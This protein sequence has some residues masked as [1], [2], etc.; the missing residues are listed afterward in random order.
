MTVQL[1]VAYSDVFTVG[2]GVFAGG[3]Y[4]CARNQ[5]VSNVHNAMAAAD[6][7]FF[8]AFEKCMSNNTPSIDKPLAN[9]ESWSRNEIANV[10]N[11]RHRKV[12]MQTGSADRVIGPN[13]MG[14]LGKQL[15]EFTDT[16]NVIYVT[17][18][19]AAHTF[20]A[21]FDSRGDN[22][23]NMSESPYISDCD[24]DG[25]GA[26]LQ[27]LYGDLNPHNTG[28]LTGELIPFAQTGAY[29]APGMDHVAYL[30][31]PASCQDSSTVCKLH[32]VLH[33]CTQGY[34]MIGNQF[35]NNTGYIPWA[36]G[37]HSSP[38]A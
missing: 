7:D 14:Q 26:V 10:A 2:F 20:P 36:G 1:G 24:Y 27:W 29:G 38:N 11:L 8:Q 28:L 21:G 23:C 3:P 25:A 30:Y 35:I 9:M 19:G 37:N 13:V 18:S 34:S 6:L 15:Q 33:G 17:T 32:I 22:P 31:L 5:N 4:D 16:A 12:Y